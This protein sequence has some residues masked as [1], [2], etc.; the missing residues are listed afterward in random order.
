M[1]TGCLHSLFSQQLFMSTCQK[2]LDHRSIFGS[3]RREKSCRWLLKSRLNST[4][5]P[6]YRRNQRSVNAWSSFLCEGI[7]PI[8]CLKLT[9]CIPWMSF[10]NGLNPKT[11]M[12]QLDIVHPE[13][14]NLGDRKRLNFQPLWSHTDAPWLPYS[15]VMRCHSASWIHSIA[16]IQCSWLLGGMWGTDGATDVFRITRNQ[17]HDL[18]E[19]WMYFRNVQSLASN[20]DFGALKATITEVLGSRDG[21]YYME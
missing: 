7:F 12:M 4:K 2:S 13:L 10:A 15:T 8:I 5:S 6:D 17:E 21:I 3:A 11:S 20:S 16:L 18:S 1:A 19:R 9:C 14:L